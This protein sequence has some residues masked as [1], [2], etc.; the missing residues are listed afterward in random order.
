MCGCLF[1]FKQKLLSISTKNLALDLYYYLCLKYLICHQNLIWGLLYIINYDNII[2]RNW[3]IIISLDHF[4]IIWLRAWD[5]HRINEAVNSEVFLNFNPV[6]NLY[7]KFTRIEI[8][9]KDYAL[10]KNLTS[11]CW[12]LIEQTQSIIHWNHSVNIPGIQN[13]NHDVNMRLSNIVGRLSNTSPFGQKITAS[14]TYHKTSN[15]PKSS[16]TRQQ[17]CLH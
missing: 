1:N 14:A 10:L 5:K 13:N 7:I 3:L 17:Y 8:G 6:W 16:I 12:I 9:T 2:I 15:A 11:L 4:Q